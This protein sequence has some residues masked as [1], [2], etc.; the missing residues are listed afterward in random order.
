MPFY[1]NFP[2]RNLH[3]MKKHFERMY[4]EF[5]DGEEVSD[6]MYDFYPP[7]NVQNADNA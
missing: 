2:G 3:H 6:D 1:R 7:A 5:M 4:D